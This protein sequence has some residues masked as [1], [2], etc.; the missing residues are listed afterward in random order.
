MFS[1]AK[2]SH[3]RFYKYFKLCKF[4]VHQYTSDTY[5]YV[6]ERYKRAQKQVKK[7]NMNVNYDGDGDA[8]KTQTIATTTNWKQR[9]TQ[10]KWAQ[11][12]WANRKKIAV[13]HNVDANKWATWS[14]CHAHS[15]Y[16]CAYEWNTFTR[17]F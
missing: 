1:E 6:Y 11:F 15:L 5:V 4:G 14:Y 17:Y 16:V 8:N 7:E 13:Q 12:K 2:I 9:M 10:N 3:N